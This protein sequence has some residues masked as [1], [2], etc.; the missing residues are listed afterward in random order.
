MDKILEEFKNMEEVIKTAQKWKSGE[1]IIKN[2]END[3]ASLYEKMQLKMI[4]SPDREM[5]QKE[6]EQKSEELRK[7]KELK[8]A[9][10]KKVNASFE[11]QKKNIVEQIDEEISKY[12][13][14]KEDRKNAEE[15]RDKEK[16]EKYI[17]NKLEYTSS[18]IALSLAAIDEAKLS[19][20]EALEAQSEYDELY[21]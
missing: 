11:S 8:D 13:K 3:V 12:V 15:A 2:K 18:C 9:A 14:T 7:L 4:G 16:L 17:D 21:K 19:F 6:Y 10:D 5:V 20:L 1:D